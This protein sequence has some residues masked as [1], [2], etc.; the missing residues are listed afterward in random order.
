MQSGHAN[1]GFGMHNR[2]WK[3]RWTELTGGGLGSGQPLVTVP[4]DGQQYTRAARRGGL[5]PQ[6]ERRAVEQSQRTH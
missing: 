1:R 6:V 2:A 3:H 4:E 5:A